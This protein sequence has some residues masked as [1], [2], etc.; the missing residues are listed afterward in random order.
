MQMKTKLLKKVRKEFS[1]F[2]DHK[3]NRWNIIQVSNPVFFMMPLQGYSY[4]ECMICG[5]MGVKWLSLRKTIKGINSITRDLQ[6]VS[7]MIYKMGND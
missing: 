7:K 5:V 1:F 3:Q 4:A 6:Y 2:Y